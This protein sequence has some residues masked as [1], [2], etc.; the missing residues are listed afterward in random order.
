MFADRYLFVPAKTW[1]D[2]RQNLLWPVHV[3]KVLYPSE[4][5]R[6]GANVFQE[7]ILG[8]MRA[9]IRDLKVVAE[10]L[11]LHPELVQ[12]IVATQLQPQGW[13]DAA[14]KLTPAGIAVLDEAED[15]RLELRVGYGFQ[16]AISGAWLPRFVA[17][18]PEI[19][20]LENDRQNRPVFLLDRERGRPEV[21][22]ILP[23]LVGASA[24]QAGLTAAYA[25]Y[26]KDVGAARRDDRSIESGFHLQAIE[27]IASEATPMYL[28]CELYRDEGQPQPW[29]VSDPFRL[30]WAASWLRKPLLDLA[31]RNTGLISKMKKLVPDVPADNCSAAEWLCQVEECVSFE[32]FGDY[33]FL[34]G[35]ELIREHLGRILRQRKKIEGRE[36]VHNEELGTL[37]GE[38]NNL[39]EAVLKWLLRQW[40][41]DTRSWPNKKYWSRDEATDVFRNLGLP[42]LSSRVIDQLAGQS[43]G[44]IADAIRTQNK[45]LKAL[46]AGAVFCAAERPDH[47]FRHL[48]ADDLALDRLPALADD[49]NKASGHASGVKADRDQVQES[50]RFAVQWMAQFHHWY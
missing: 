25:A 47:P 5:Q 3:W 24:D 34:D 43:L 6:L 10:F 14:F 32:L 1:L 50:A 29:L 23:H 13:L 20:P 17:N 42:G 44:A 22:F 18:L 16:D 19:S 26:R 30:R 31:P 36:K 9:G 2:G 37:A 48:N 35:Q 21:P 46:L 39:L 40:P 27:N 8:L 38:V 12:F 28:W 33:P 15:S 45:P 41:I 7:A 11:A 49:R 4:D